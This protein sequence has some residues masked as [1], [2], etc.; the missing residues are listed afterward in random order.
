MPSVSWISPPT[1]AVVGRYVLEPEIFQ[2]LRQTQAGVGG[3]IQLTDG[4]ASLL[5]TR[6]VYGRRYVGSR[7]DCGSKAG[8]FQATVDLGRKYHGLSPV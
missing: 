8:F 1:P 5:K 7:Y 6:G 2:H 3:E 4:I